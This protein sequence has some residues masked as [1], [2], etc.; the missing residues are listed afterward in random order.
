MTSN[1][2]ENLKLSELSAKR[3]YEFALIM[4]PLKP[5]RRD[6]FHRLPAGAAGLGPQKEELR[7]SSLR[8]RRSPPPGDGQTDSAR[9]IRSMRRGS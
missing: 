1:L 9:I 2:L 5:E 7:S 8:N 6:G 4:Q 3:A